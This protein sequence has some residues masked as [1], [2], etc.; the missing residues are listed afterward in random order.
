[1]SKKTRKKSPNT[2]SGKPARGQSMGVGEN[3]ASEN[4]PDESEQVRQ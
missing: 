3:T 1:M 4:P 2:S